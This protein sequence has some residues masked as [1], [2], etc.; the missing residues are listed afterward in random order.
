M[1]EDYKN[2]LLEKENRFEREIFNVFMRYFMVSR[3]VNP[4]KEGIE[5]S[6]GDSE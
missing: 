6:R 2:F 3:V 5:T 1:H 4:S